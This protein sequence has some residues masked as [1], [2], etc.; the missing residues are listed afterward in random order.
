MKSICYFLLAVFCTLIIISGC[1]SSTDSKPISTA[2]PVLVSPAD[3]SSN[4]SL[5]PTFTWTGS[6]DK[7]EIGSNNTFTTIIQS[8]NVTGTTYTVTTPLQANT[9][10]FWRAGLTAGSTVYWCTNIYSFRTRP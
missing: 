9:L 1:D 4:I 7:L 6:A 2:A 8:A 10:Y 3:T 5:T